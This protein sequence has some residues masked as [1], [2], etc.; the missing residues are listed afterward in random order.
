MRRT[1]SHA[2][3]KNAAGSLPT[4]VRAR[5]A[6]YFERA[7]RWELAVDGIIELLQDIRLLRRPRSFSASSS[8]G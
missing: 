1:Q 8:S 2:F 6:G 5:Y 3:W 4:N 7:E